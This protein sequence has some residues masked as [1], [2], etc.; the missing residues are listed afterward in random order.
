MECEILF[1]GRKYCS[2]DPDPV[3]NQSMLRFKRAWMA[4]A[5][6][7]VRVLFIVA[8]IMSYVGLVVV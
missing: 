3:D 4:W 2:R 1:I 5:P 8:Y 7:R 6:H